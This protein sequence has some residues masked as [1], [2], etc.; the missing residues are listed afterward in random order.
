MTTLSIFDVDPNGSG[1]VKNLNLG[2]LE[3]LGELAPKV[4]NIRKVTMGTYGYHEGISDEQVAL[5]TK[6]QKRLV[7]MIK[8]WE[9]YV[10]GSKVMFSHTD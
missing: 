6:I 9:K 3:L 7:K 4:A 5:L 10:K 8:D 2:C 1:D